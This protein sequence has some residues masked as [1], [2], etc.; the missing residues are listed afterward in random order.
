MIWS[1]GLCSYLRRGEQR[2]GHATLAEIGGVARMRR[3]RGARL[4][5]AENGAVKAGGGGGGD[6]NGARIFLV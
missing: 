6:Y 1:R 5:D 4:T 3:I 2:Q